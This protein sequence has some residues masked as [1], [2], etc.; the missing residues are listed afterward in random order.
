MKAAWKREEH[1]YSLQLEPICHSEANVQH[2]L[3]HPLS[4]LVLG[5]EYKGVKY[6]EMVPILI[7]A[8]QEQQRQIEA[9]QKEVEQ[10]KKDKQ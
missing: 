8:M 1:F 6:V 2:G 7:Q 5:H 3:L 10:L 9:L 4:H